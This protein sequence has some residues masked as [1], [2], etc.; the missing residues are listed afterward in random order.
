V[1]GFKI[2]DR[3]L[4]SRGFRFGA[5]AE[6]LA[7]PTK[8]VSVIV[9]IPGRLSDEDAVALPFG[10]VTALV[11]LDE[12]KLKA[13]EHI[14]INGASGAV[15]TM[16]IQIAKHRGAE[17]TAVCSA[18]NAALVKSLGAD[19]VIDYRATDFTQGATRYDLIMDTVGNASYDRVKHLLKPGGRFL[20]VI[21]NAWE[22]L[23][24]GRRP[25]VVGA[26]QESKAF[27]TAN[28]QH[29]LDLAERGVLRAVI[30]SVYP[31]EDIAR[32]HARVDT[33]HKVGSVVVTLGMGREAQ[34]A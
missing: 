19:H 9:K 29:L 12:G 31:F 18:G 15:G 10:G 8:G 4:A 25:D 6:L 17:I 34:A 1:E 33:G 13:G 26:D 27:T 21:G 24:G 23:T 7:V 14:L 11:F 20:M 2:G 5:H 28:Y 3:V 30:D 16:T 22:M 32:A